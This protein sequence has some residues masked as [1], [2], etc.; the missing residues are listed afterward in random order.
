MK[1]THITKQC[2]C[3]LSPGDIRN[4]LY[5]TLERGDFERGGKSV[6]KNIEECI[7]LGSGEHNISE[8]RSFVLYHNNSPRWSEVIKL[9]IPIDRFRGS[10]LRFEFRHCSTKD[11][12]EKKL[13]GFAF[14]PL[15]RE[16]G[17]TL[18]DESH[19]L[20]VY[21][22]DENTTFSNHALYLGLPCCKDDFNGCPNIP[23]SLIFQRSTKETLWISTQ[24]S[25]TKL[26]QN[27]DLLALLKWKAH[28][29]RVMDILGRLRH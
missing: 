28:P 15:M 17:T 2:V 26:T 16:D 7:S 9:P 14:T 20:Y 23:S 18:S 6:Q 29:D 11:K 25:S 3:F 24:L 13:F 12:G 21:K 1:S 5:L 8:Y 19:E 27:V 4:D 22:C 10:H